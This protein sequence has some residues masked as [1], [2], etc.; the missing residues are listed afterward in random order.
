MYSTNY[1]MSIFGSGSPS[2]ILR[3]YS[4]PGGELVYDER[5]EYYPQSLMVACSATGSCLV[6]TIPDGLLVCP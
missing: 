6:L 5:F 3:A 1:N 4:L 2:S